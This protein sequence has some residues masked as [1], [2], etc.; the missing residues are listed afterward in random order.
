MLEE[1]AA[2]QKLEEMR[3]VRPGEGEWDKKRAALARAPLAKAAVLKRPFR[4]D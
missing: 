1:K 3:Q 4:R 2:L